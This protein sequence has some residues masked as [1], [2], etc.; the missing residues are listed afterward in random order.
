MLF[1]DFIKIFGILV[2]LD[3]ILKINGRLIFYNYIFI[4]GVDSLVFMMLV[5]FS[6]VL[7]FFIFLDDLI[8]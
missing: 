7:F 4:R 6:S 1:C 3:S 2:K 8:C 5:I